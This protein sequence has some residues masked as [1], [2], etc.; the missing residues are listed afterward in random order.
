MNIIIFI[1]ILGIL[2]LVHELGHFI[3]A[4]LNDIYVEEFGFGLPPRLIGKKIG[5]TIY[6]LNLLPF[7]GFVKLFGEEYHELNKPI[8]QTLKKRAFAYKSPLAKI[9]VMVGGV[10]GNFLLGWLLISFLF[11]QG[12]PTPTNKV[13]IDSI[14]ANSPAQ[15]AGLKEKDI[16]LKIIQYPLSSTT[17][18]VNLTKKFLG[19]NIT[20]TIQRGGHTFNVKITPRVTAP[21][22]QGPLGVVIT[23]FIEK[24]YIWYQAP[25]YGLIESFKITTQIL[26][27]L[28]KMVIQF[29][30][31]QGSKVEVTGPIGIARYT[32]QAIKFGQNALLELLA[33]LS[34]NL[35]V[36]NI[37]PFPALDG[38]R[39]IFVL[40][41]WLTKKRVNGKIERNLNFIG[42][43]VLI[44]LAIIISI[45]DIIKIFQ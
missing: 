15:A 8:D 12:V 5:E 3:T 4:K 21:K 25:F 20:L 32:S 37:L 24:K 40:Y 41:E 2:I 23:N 7:G 1:L 44:S 31:F 30:T 29:V 10:I 45:N 22:G 36:V 18:F 34:L 16:I 26:K 14:Q 33:L 6:S 11:T 13:I 9:S 17:D 38:G 35:G 42:F 19:K 39:L 43:A 28:I 27:E